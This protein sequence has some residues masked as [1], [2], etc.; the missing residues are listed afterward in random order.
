MSNYT[1]LNTSIIHTKNSSRGWWSRTFNWK[2]TY[3][4]TKYC[5]D[6]DSRISRQKFN[7]DNRWRHDRPCVAKTSS[8][9][10]SS[11]KKFRQKRRVAFLVLT[12]DEQP[13]CTS[14]RPY[15]STPIRYRQ[16][17]LRLHSLR[18]PLQATRL[19]SKG[20]ANQYSMPRGTSLKP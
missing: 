16:S 18:R 10:L 3:E 7:E 4:K 17:F 1:L 13:C 2:F 14:R 19:L 8:R 11:S 15:A 9:S 12:A 5:V 6:T 20:G